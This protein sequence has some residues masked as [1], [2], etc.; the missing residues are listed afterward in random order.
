[1]TPKIDDADFYKSIN[2]AISEKRHV[3]YLQ[4]VIKKYE[5]Y[6]KEFEMIFTSKNLKNSVYKFRVTYLLKKLVWRDVE[7]FGEQTFLDLAETII[8]SMGWDNDHMHGFEIPEQQRKP[9]P[10]LTKSSNAFFAPGWED[11]PHPTFKTD[12]ICIRDIDY[13]KLPKLDFIFDFGDEHRFYIEFE[14]NREPERKEKK[15]DFP[16]VI[17]QRGVGPKQYPEYE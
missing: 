8:D 1:M 7:L 12:E 15:A 16:R 2:R 10:F 6:K 14:G 13:G 5:E 9:D 11:D 17:D 4:E 3:D